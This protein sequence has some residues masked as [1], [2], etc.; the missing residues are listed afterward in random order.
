MYCWETLYMQAFYQHNLLIVEQQVND[1][2]PQYQLA[3][4]AR[5][6]LRIR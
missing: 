3:Y 2:N 1:I 6:L 5:D 4:T